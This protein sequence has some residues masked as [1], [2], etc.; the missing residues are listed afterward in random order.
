M[1]LTGRQMRELVA[2]K[3]QLKDFLSHYS[4]PSHAVIN[5]DETRVVQKG[6]K[7]VL[8]RV[9]A[10]NKERANVRSTRHQTVASLLTFV[11]AD[12]SVLLSVYILKGRF[13]DG[14]EA[15]VNFRMEDAPRV[16]R[17]T[18]PR[19]YIFKAVLIKVAEEF[20]IKY[21]GLS[22][23]LFGDQLAAHRRPDIVDFAI[24]LGL[25][26]ISLAKNTS[27]ITQPLDEAP[28]GILQAARVRRN[29]EAVMDGML[30]NSDT[31]DALMMAAYQAERQAFS[32]PVI[33]GA[34]R[35]RGLWPFDADLMQANVRANLG[36]VESGETP[37]EA[38]RKA[39]A[40][41]IQAAQE[42]V[43]K[44]ATVS[45]SGKAV[46]KRAV[47]H[48]PWYLMEQQRLMEE[49]AAKEVAAKAARQEERDQK[50]EE[51]GQRLV[52][53]AV[54]RENHRCRVCQDKVHRGGK[55]WMGCQCD[56][57][58]VCPG[59]SKTMAAGLAFAGHFTISVQ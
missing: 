34:F 6:E 2:R 45:S 30:T 57:F 58:W 48:S 28:F 37:A 22:A 41:E 52:E 39:A 29:E 43:N 53:K 44:A 54:A 9:E 49:E 5:Y 51:K 13:G 17:G 47:V 36:M 38:A 27:H 26:L 11:A 55:H 46:V 10:A 40:E 32:R 23:L 59:C 1:A 4:F 16:T 3:W 20:H 25:F 8:R 12:G 15:A 7:L 19:F 18:W 56:V 33:V 24:G 14:D 31:R 50:K 42:R 21:P 35:R